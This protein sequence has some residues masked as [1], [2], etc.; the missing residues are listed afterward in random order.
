[1]VTEND[2]AKIYMLETSTTPEAIT[3]VP[4]LDIRD[5]QSNVSNGI[6]NM[7]TNVTSHIFAASK[8]NGGQEL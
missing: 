6:V 4:S 2:Q 7:A 1:M 5:A 8:P 3:I